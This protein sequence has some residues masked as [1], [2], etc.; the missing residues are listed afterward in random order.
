MIARGVVDVDALRSAVAPLAEG[1]QWF[2][3]LAKGA[4]GLLKVILVP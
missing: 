2:G 4:P 3:R 1:A